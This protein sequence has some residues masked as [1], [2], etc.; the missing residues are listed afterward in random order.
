MA[1][2]EPASAKQ[3]LPILVKYTQTMKDLLTEIQKVIPPGGTTRRVLYPGPPGSPRWWERSRG[4][5]T[6]QRLLELVSR[7]AAPDKPV[8]ERTHPE[9]ALQGRGGRARGLPDPDKTN[10][11]SDGLQIVLGLRT[12]PGLQSGTRNRPPPPVRKRGPPLHSA[13][14]A[15]GLPDGES[16]S[17]PTLQGCLQL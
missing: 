15:S 17:P 5:G 10:P 12:E 2:R 16:N 14:F 4:S 1:S 8:S 6:L 13:D 7:R 3:A 11:R 9:P